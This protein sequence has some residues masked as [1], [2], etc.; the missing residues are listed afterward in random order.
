MSGWLDWPAYVSRCGRPAGVGIVEQ[1]ASGSST[2]ARGQR[3]VG[4]SFDGAFSGQGTWQQFLAV[5]EDSLLAV[6]DTVPD[7]V[8]A[9]FYVGFPPSR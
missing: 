3:V 7:H 1:P 8:A 4:Y 2:F 5:P 9:Q 6:P